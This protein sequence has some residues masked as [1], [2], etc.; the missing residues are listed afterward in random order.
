MI[1]KAQNRSAIS[2]TVFSIVI[3]K[4]KTTS[5]FNFVKHYGRYI[6]KQSSR[7]RVNNP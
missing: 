2:G 3:R 7:K 1:E 4:T 5:F 6:N